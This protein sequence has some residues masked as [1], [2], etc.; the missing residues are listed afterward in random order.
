M[1]LRGQRWRDAGRAP[2]L[3]RSEPRLSQVRQAWGR[4]ASFSGSPQVWGSWGRGFGEWVGV[5]QDPTMPQTQTWGPELPEWDGASLP[6]SAG[7]PPRP[8]FCPA[9][10]LR[11]GVLGA[12]RTPEALSGCLSLHCPMARPRPRRH[13]LPTTGGLSGS[14]LI[15]L[16]PR[17]ALLPSCSDRSEQARVQ[18][19]QR[20]APAATAVNWTRRR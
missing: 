18:Q 14:V 13:P 20:V 3:G 4:V 16:A 5:R 1:G 15:Y 12:V 11:D 9:W 8:L 6:H 2:A 17:M 19:T 10:A 7:A